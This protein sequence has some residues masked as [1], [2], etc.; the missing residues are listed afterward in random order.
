MKKIS[1]FTVI[2]GLIATPFSSFACTYEQAQKKM[3][4]VINLQ[5]VYNREMIEH[6]NKGQ[7]YP[8][9]ERRGAFA[10]EAAAVGVLLA[11]VSSHI[12]DDVTVEIDSRVCEQYDALQEKYASASH[13]NAP[14]T[15]APQPS[16]ADCTTEKLWGR[17]GVAM[18]EQVALSQ[19]GKFSKN[20]D[21]EFMQMGTWIGQY[22]TTDLAQA[23]DY[24][25]QY[26]AKLATVK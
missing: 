14:V 20:D 24:M 1:L 22:S 15:V 10:E 25:S 21:S 3:I 6:M 4:E 17:Y 2:L 7:E 26:E 13:Q 11:E 16:S 8:G 19:A 12:E 23:C 5:Q 18:Q 9:E